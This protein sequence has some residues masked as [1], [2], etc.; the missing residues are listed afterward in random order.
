M[1]ETYAPLTYVP[2]FER[3][4]ANLAIPAPPSYYRPASQRQKRKTARRANNRKR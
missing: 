1:N 3:G 4:P 2:N